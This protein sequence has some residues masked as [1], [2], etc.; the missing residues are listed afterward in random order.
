MV[1]VL[2]FH[3]F[4]WFPPPPPPAAFYTVHTT[5][6]FVHCGAVLL[7]HV[8]HFYTLRFTFYVRVVYVPPHLCPLPHHISCA[9]VP[10]QFHRFP[11]FTVATFTFTFATPFTFIFGY[12]LT[13]QFIWF[14]SP[15]H[16]PHRTTHTHTPHHRATLPV[17]FTFPATF[18]YTVY[19]LPPHT[20]V[21]AYDHLRFVTPPHHHTYIL[22]SRLPFA[23]LRIFHVPLPPLHLRSFLRSSLLPVRYSSRSLLR[24]FPHVHTATP[25][26]LP[27]HTPFLPHPPVLL[28]CSHFT[29]LPVGLRSV[30]SPPHTHDYVRSTL[31]AYDSFTRSVLH[32]CTFIYRVYV[33]T[34]AHPRPFTRPAYTFYATVLHFTTRSRSRFCAGV[35]SYLPHVYVWFLFTHVFVPHFS[36]HLCLRLHLF[37]CT[38]STCHHVLRSRVWFVLP[39]HLPHAGTTTAPARCSRF[40]G[41]HLHPPSSTF[42]VLRLVH[43][44][45]APFLFPTFHFAVR[46]THTL[47][48]AGCQ[49]PRLHH[50][51]V[52]H[53]TT[54]PTVRLLAVRRSRSVPGVYTFALRSVLRSS[55]VPTAF[56][57]VPV[58][59][60]HTGS[61]SPLPVLF[62]FTQ[63][64]VL[65][66]YVC[67]AATRS[68]RSPVH[69]PTTR[70]TAFYR[71]CYVQFYTPPPHTVPPRAPA[72]RAT[73]RVPVPRTTTTTPVYHHLTFPVPRFVPVPFTCSG[74][75]PPTFA[76][77]PRLPRLPFPRFQF[78]AT[79]FTFPGL[80]VPTACAFTLYRF[81]TVL[82]VY[83]DHVYVH[84]TLPPQQFLYV[85]LFTFRFTTTPFTH[86][87]CTQC[88]FTFTFYTTY[89]PL[90]LPPLLHRFTLVGS[91]TFCFALHHG[92][93]HDFSR[94]FTPLRLLHAPRILLPVYVPFIL[95]GCFYLPHLFTRLF[96]HV[97]Y[98]LR[99]RFH[100]P[101]YLPR[102]VYIFLFPRRLFYHHGSRLHFWFPTTTTFCHIFVRSYILRL[103]TPPHTTAFV[104]HFCT[105]YVPRFTLPVYGSF[106][107]SRVHVVPFSRA[108]A[109]CYHVLP[110]SRCA[111]SPTFVPYSSP[112]HTAFSP[113]LTFPPRSTPPPQFLCCSISTVHLHLPPPPPPPPHTRFTFC[114]FTFS[115]TTLR[116]VPV[117]LRFT[118]CCSTFT[119]FISLFTFSSHLP[120]SVLP[121][122][123]VLPQFLYLPLPAHLPR[124][125]F[126][127]FPLIPTTLLPFTA[128]TTTPFTRFYGSTFTFYVTFVGCYFARSP[129]TARPAPP[130]HHGWLCAFT[131][132]PTTTYLHGCL[133]FCLYILRYARFPTT[134]C[135]PRSPFVYGSVHTTPSSRFPFWLLRVYHTG[136]TFRTVPRYVYCSLFT[137]T[138]SSHR[139]RSH[140]TPRSFVPYFPVLQFSTVATTGY[141]FY[142]FVHF[143]HT[144]LFTILRSVYHH[145]HTFGL[146]PAAFT[147]HFY[148]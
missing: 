39:V 116:S 85:V 62:P 95:F 46:S 67:R 15:H 101:T 80:P 106:T 134:C 68:T 81:T 130:H 34:F 110:G 6:I 8:L 54:P 72:V 7:H 21:V 111:R 140:F 27:V 117:L 70:L 121:P 32:T 87:H 5:T 33:L 139:L 127:T 26:L 42:P 11:H 30:R 124:S 17:T 48:S 45:T 74:S 93:V 105:R 120:R 2:P 44:T 122:P 92:Y 22:R 145:T 128:T 4:G 14:I 89:T 112:L 38:R 88:I 144:R 141:T 31:V 146:V 135:S 132:F 28:F 63:R 96:P 36:H 125:I 84:V 55:H 50:H 103:H 129:P 40:P 23:F 107:F 35:R 16:P 57:F 137:H 1:H 51:H 94:W 64:L 131:L 20:G 114:T 10:V 58:T 37:V 82:P 41:H 142:H 69:L 97:H 77:V 61:R 60:V 148:V 75:P 143:Y 91:H 104:L 98:H 109:F 53:P 90:P 138:H 13:T 136:S 108:F 9:P 76:F 78:H 71:L 52:H 126:T 147:T 43:H 118:F 102:C 59:V 99:S 66:F 65:R 119:T 115:S 113:P 83:V 25:R 47:H 86:H 12:V 56:T 24:A 133:A 18:C 3:T 73:P 79:H 19:L 123:H 49:F 100:I 29:F